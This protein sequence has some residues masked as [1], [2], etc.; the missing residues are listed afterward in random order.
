MAKILVIDDEK[1]IRN[2][3]KDILEYEKHTVTDASDG[4]EGLNL[5]TTEKFDVILC[6]IKMPKMDGIEVLE[7]LLELHWFKI[8]S[9]H[10]FN[11]C[12]EINSD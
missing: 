2:T 10:N 12:L 4:V 5:A 9:L 7:K 11:L 6:D 8:P 1:S 3:L